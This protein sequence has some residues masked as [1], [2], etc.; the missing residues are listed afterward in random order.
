MFGVPG[1]PGN[2]LGLRNHEPS[3]SRGAWFASQQSLTFH[4]EFHKTIMTPPPQHPIHSAI[5]PLDSTW[6]LSYTDAA[7]RFAQELWAFEQKLPQA[8]APV[9]DDIIDITM[10]RELQHLVNKFVEASRNQCT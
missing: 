4:G 5:S 8:P 10:Q 3:S 1:A 9:P 7:A 2:G 6:L